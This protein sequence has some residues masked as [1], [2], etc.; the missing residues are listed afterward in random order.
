MKRG[1]REKAVENGLVKEGQGPERAGSTL[2]A[3]RQGERALR[4][5]PQNGRS[6]G[7]RAA[8]GK[9]EG[10][11]GGAV[12]RAQREDKGGACSRAETRV[13]PAS[14]GVS[15]GS[16]AVGPASKGVSEGGRAGRPGWAGS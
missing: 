9:G 14:R 12:R 13:R 5:G 10:L 2:R 6:P 15:E 11:E 16:L 3:G 7:G 1:A 4:A 8:G